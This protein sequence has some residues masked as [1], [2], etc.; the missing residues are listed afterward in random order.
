DGLRRRNLGSRKAQWHKVRFLARK[1]SCSVRTGL[2]FVCSFKRLPWDGE[3]DSGP[4]GVARKASFPPTA[5]S[6]VAVFRT[7]SSRG[8]SHH[9]RPL[10]TNQ[11]TNS[12]SGTS[13]RRVCSL[14]IQSRHRRSLAF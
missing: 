9:A 13:L 8:S 6:E 14:R 7:P 11:E 2:G 1:R 4:T 3:A 5:A 12:L 10:R